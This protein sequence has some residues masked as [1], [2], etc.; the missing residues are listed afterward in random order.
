MRSFWWT[1]STFFSVWSADRIKFIDSQLT[2][3]IIATSPQFKL[4]LIR[5][6][7]RNNN[8]NSPQIWNQKEKNM[9][10]KSIRE[11]SAAFSQ[12][13]N[14]KYFSLFKNF[15]RS[16]FNILLVIFLHIFDCILWFLQFASGAHS[17]KKTT[18]NILLSV[19]Y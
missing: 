11:Y 19:G 10:K 6:V 8:K 1:F 9:R 15:W 18:W 14:I 12:F 3:V 13:H 16:F 5:Q 7:Q 17:K 4:Q 2:P